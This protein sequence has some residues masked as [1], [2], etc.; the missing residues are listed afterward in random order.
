MRGKQN[1][2][3]GNLPKSN[4]KDPPIYS[5]AQAEPPSIRLTRLG[6]DLGSRTLSTLLALDA[7]SSALG[8]GGG[9]LGLLSLLAALGSGLLLLGLLDS[10]LAGGGT[11]LGAHAAALLDHIKGG[12]DDGTLV[13]D[14]T[15]GALLG[16][17]LFMVKT[18]PVSNC[19]STSYFASPV[20][21]LS[22]ICPHSTAAPCLP[23]A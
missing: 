19:S 9:V 23:N 4:H 7:L 20:I 22:L 17:F 5:P 8:G 11:S 12:T 6:G 18:D 13:L 1:S 16:N 21:V 3:S 2:S 15:A 14:D 10:L